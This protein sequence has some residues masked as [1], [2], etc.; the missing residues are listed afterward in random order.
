MNSLFLFLSKL[1]VSNSPKKPKG[2]VSWNHRVLP[3]GESGW[4]TQLLTTTITGQ[5]RQSLKAPPP[6]HEQ[7]CADH[8]PCPVVSCREG[9][10]QMMSSTGSHQEILTWEKSLVYI[11][12]NKRN[13]SIPELLQQVNQMFFKLH[14]FPWNSRDWS[15]SIPNSLAGA[16]EAILAERQHSVLFG[17]CECRCEW[18]QDMWIYCNPL[19]TSY[20]KKE[21][22]LAISVRFHVYFTD[23]LTECTGTFLHMLACLSQD[24]L[25]WLQTVSFWIM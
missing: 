10:A 20:L 4:L 24:S 25:T 11:R 19:E 3:I 8:E 17:L 13:G 5:Q 12:L 15:F 7:T 2:K 16:H 6:K 14:F 18:L 23:N 21:F 22:T 9:V 1:L